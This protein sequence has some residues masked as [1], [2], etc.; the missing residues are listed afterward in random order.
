MYE[1][2]LFGDLYSEW[3]FRWWSEWPAQ[4]RPLVE[5]AAEMHAAFAA[6]AS[7]KGT[8]PPGMCIRACEREGERGALAPCFPRPT[9]G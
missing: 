8:F 1:L 2:A 7:K 3:R 6:A 4:W 5:L 9:G